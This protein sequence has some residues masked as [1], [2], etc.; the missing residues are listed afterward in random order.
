MKKI[1]YLFITFTVVMIGNKANAFLPPEFF[2]QGL[3]SIWAVLAGG[4]AV[5]L[6]PFILFFKFIKLKFK[7][8]KK[9]I[10]FLLVQNIII[11][12]F[13]G[14]FFFYQYYQPLYQDSYLFPGGHSQDS[15]QNFEAEYI[16]SEGNN[17]IEITQINKDYVDKD[18][19]YRDEYGDNKADKDYGLELEEIEKKIINQENIYFID[20]REI[21]EYDAGHIESSKHY[22]GM[23]LT[24]EK[25]KELFSLSE[26]QFNKSIFILACHDGGRGLIITKK[27]DKKNIKYII[28]GIEALEDISSQKIVKI[29]GP[30]F[31][32]YVI[33][34]K[35]YQKKY[36]MWAKDAIAMIKNGD[37]IVVVDGRHEFLYKKGHVKESVQL[38]IGRMTTEE[39]EKS[40]FKIIENKGADII[41]LCS[42]YGELFHANLLFLR[43]ERDY[44]FDDDKFHVVFNQFEEFKNNPDIEFET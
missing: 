34:E 1:I 23:D 30:V 2:V 35:K 10:S 27:F 31:A 39:Y 19:Y 21:E 11:A 6:V 42:R 4:V 26:N 5:A 44:G 36:Q 9:I 40:L 43:L 13:L 15:F 24:I 22:R 7:Q 20:V 3:S 38:N 14:V 17:D 28:G 18:G 32:D 8:H 29:T 25:I 41:I 16:L 12:I 33:F 37:K